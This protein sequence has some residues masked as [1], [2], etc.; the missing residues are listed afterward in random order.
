VRQTGA[1][2]SDAV[3]LV[4]GAQPGSEQMFVDGKELPGLAAQLQF[5]YAAASGDVG[6]TR[7]VYS[8]DVVDVDEL[9]HPAPYFSAPGCTLA[10]E[11]RERVYARC[12]GPANLTRRELYMPGW[13][14]RVDG[15]PR[16]VAP[17]GDIFESV[18]LP[19]G[20][21][22]VTFDFTPPNMSY[23]YAAFTLGVLT[24]IYQLL[25]YVRLRFARSVA[26]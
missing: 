22:T 24:F 4:A 9:P 5:R 14:A 19:A 16:D 8:D 17:A 2:F 21:S 26:A 12:A 23:G 3:W 6:A 7:T 10:A 1:S 20:N 18:A 25:A 11:S 15:A 13:T